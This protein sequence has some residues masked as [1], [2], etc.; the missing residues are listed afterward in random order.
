[1]RQVSAS[2]AGVNRERLSLSRP[3]AAMVRTWNV[4]DLELS[5]GTADGGVEV[6][7]P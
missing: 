3:T 6:R 1:M 2:L 5:A 4:V 7:H